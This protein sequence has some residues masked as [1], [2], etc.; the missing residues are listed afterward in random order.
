MNR[1]DNPTLPMEKYIQI[2]NQIKELDEM[3]LDISSS[4]TIQACTHALK[5]TFEDIGL[6][7][8]ECTNRLKITN[9]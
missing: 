7:T 9:A 3:K 1:A 6:Y 8:E 5:A 2:K 4:K